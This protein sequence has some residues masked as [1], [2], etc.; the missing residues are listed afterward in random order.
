MMWPYP[1][2][3]AHRGGGSL[4]PENTIAALRCGLQ[5][6]FSAVEFDVMLSKDEVPIV[7][8]DP[9]LGRTVSGSGSVADYSAE[10]LMQLDA[11]AWFDERYAG[12]LVPSFEQVVRFC[13]A[14]DIWMNIEIKPVPGFD[15][16]TGRVVAQ[17]TARLFA[18]VLA[19]KKNEAKNNAAVSDSTRASLP[20][21]SS[22]SCEALRAAQRTEA[23]IPRACLF[24]R[25]PLDWCEKL[26]S[27]GAV[28]IDTN[29][30]HLSAKQ[31]HAIK[32]ADFGL[33][34]YTVNDPERARE[35]LSWGV[36]AIC[37]DRIDLLGAD[38][39]ESQD[40]DAVE[41]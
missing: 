30:K 36:D 3:I 11:G 23:A 29:H 28:A 22:F 14:N 4:A 10:E 7:M 21:F 33:F 24:D 17:T 13:R 34:C 2:M 40:Q 39:A 19:L 26:T 6:G 32:R 8:H 16:V 25:V 38:F 41:R 31:A 1:K 27:L 20:L 37:T 15:E 35:V 9:Q 5:H 18:D 12:E